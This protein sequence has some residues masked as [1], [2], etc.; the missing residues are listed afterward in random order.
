MKLSIERVSHAH[1]AKATLCE[2][3]LA[4]DAGEIVGVV[5]PNGAGKTTLLEIALGI[6]APS[7]GRARLGDDD[8]A[9]LPRQEIARRAAYVPQA[10]AFD[11]ALTVRELVTLGRYAHRDRDEAAIDRAIAAA[12]LTEL[13]ERPLGAVSGGER[14]RAALA[15]AFA[16]ASPLLV[17]DEPTASLDL[18]HAA[19]LL[20]LVNA[21]REKGS[22]LVAIHDLSAAARICD[23]VALLKEGQLIA[24]GPPREVMTEA[25]IG[26]AFG[27]EVRAIESEGDLVFVPR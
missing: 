5:G 25:R 2:V 24:I 23:R 26:D 3:T 11:E 27:G 22:A 13:A 4:V 16:Q 7:A 18:G 12:G 9:S 14:Q 10:F 19:R 1:G 17:L 15:R 21:Q 8:V 20:A 6:V